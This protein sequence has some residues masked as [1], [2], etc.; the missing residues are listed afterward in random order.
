MNQNLT[1]VKSNKLIEASYRLSLMEQRLVLF[2][3]SQM[4]SVGSSYGKKDEFKIS[5][6]SFQAFFGLKGESIYR[7][8]KAAEET[9]FN[10]KFNYVNPKTGRLRKTRWISAV[11]YDGEEGLIVQFSQDIIPFLSQIKGNYTQYQ[12]E[13]ITNL[14]SVHAIR[15]YELCLQ[16]LKIGERLFELEKIKAMLGIEDQYSE[17][18]D[19]NKWVIKPSVDQINKHTDIRIQVEPIRKLRKIVSLK[20][21]IKSKQPAKHKA[22][23]QRTNSTLKKLRETLEENYIH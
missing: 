13:K 19:F 21:K 9:L 17:F 18:K 4:D 2:C 7:D 8:L 10:R 3:I 23:E 20:F 11:E 22:S 6:K 12:L 16:Y 15:I 14:N 1:V 5:A